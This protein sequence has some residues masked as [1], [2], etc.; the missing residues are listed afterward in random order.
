MKEKI[1]EMLITK[2]YEQSGDKF[3][4]IIKV[5]VGKIVQNGAEHIQ[6]AEDKVEIE[7]L[8]GSEDLSN[9]EEIRILTSWNLFINDSDMGGFL[10]YDIEEFKFFLGK[11][12]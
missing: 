6:F 9:E 3:T 11:F 2:G 7:Y 10:V 1:T 8:G 12:L 4:R 5:P